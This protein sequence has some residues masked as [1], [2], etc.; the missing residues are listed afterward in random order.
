MKNDV[1]KKILYFLCFFII[2]VGILLIGKFYNKKES[3]EQ[4]N[5]AEKFINLEFNGVI[6]SYEKIPRGMNLWIDNKYILLGFSGTCLN[7]KIS[8][9]DSI[10]KKKGSD[11]F[12]LFKRN[13]RNQ[14]VDSIVI[15]T[16][17]I[18]KYNI[19]PHQ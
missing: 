15:E 9:N 19:L 17:Y 8:I 11:L 13:S 4:K 2:L 18:E 12:F 7:E 14:I 3:V 1:L 10:V 5:I 16:G 6:T